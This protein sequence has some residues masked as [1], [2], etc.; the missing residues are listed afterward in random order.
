MIR[1]EPITL[2]GTS[3][4]LEPLFLDEQ[5]RDEQLRDEKP[6]DEKLGHHAA[7]CRVGLDPER[8]RVGAE[9]VTD[10]AGM[11]A[12]L[13]RSLAAQAAGTALAFVTRDV[14]SGTI[15]GCTR[16]MNID[17]THRRVEIGGTWLAAPWQRTRLNTEAKYLM[18]R[19]AFESWNCL[20]V[21]FKT[22]VLNEKSRRAILR[23]GAKQEG[24]L[25]Q[26]MVT[27][28]GR[29]RDSVYFSILD[30]EWP[31]VK[32]ELERKLEPTS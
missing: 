29:I 5:V 23:L 1:I 12:Y 17:R 6:G 28:T 11:R 21:E 32:A 10:E 25:R 19:H 2:E 9:G 27:W 16:F 22:D 8:W 30:S 31:G 26:H 13:E 4:R 24:I 15:V 18:L 3:V 7:L 14:S 20:R